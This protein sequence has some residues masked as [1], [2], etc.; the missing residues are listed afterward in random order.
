[1]EFYAF[2]AV[3][4]A[5]LF[6]SSF[7]RS[8]LGFG[9]ALIAMPL[10]TLLAGPR[11]AAPVVG[12]SA[13]IIAATILAANWHQADKKPVHRLIIGSLIG[14]PPGLWLLSAAPAIVVKALLGILLILFALF[15]LF[16]PSLP[17]LKHRHWA[18]FFGFIAGVLG[19]AYNTNG[20]PV[21]VYATMRQWP[22]EKFRASLQ[23]YF[24]PTGFMIASG[25]GLAGLWNADVFL[26]TL[27][28]LPAVLSGIFIGGKVNRRLEVGFFQKIVYLFLIVIG[29]LLLPI[30][31]QYQ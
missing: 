15:R 4:A 13:V 11:M 12:L 27:V 31:W 3:V 6:F 26:W 23:Y 5:I 2:A 1:M 8:A 10:L 21:V 7:C 28:G 19:G 29:V 24:L 25:H 30:N 17:G 9:D 18:L 20:P 16:Q 14:I 22:P